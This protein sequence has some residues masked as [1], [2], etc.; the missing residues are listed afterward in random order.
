MKLFS[1]LSVRNYRLFASGQVISL[2]GTWAQR[3][4][5][6]WLV[7]ELS[8]NSGV[9]LGITTGL[10]FLPMLLF[11]LYGGVLADR[12][13]KRRL[14][15]WAQVSM[16]V[17]ALV[18]GVLDLADVVQ[19]WHVYVLAAALG[20]ATAFDSPVRQAFVTELVGPSLLANAVGL[21]S[22]AFNFARVVGPAVAGL[23]IASIGTAWVFLINAS[24][25]VAVIAGLAAIRSAEL[26]VG[27][28]AARRK[29]AVLEGLRYV[30]SQPTLVAIIVV[31]GIVGCLGFN[32]QITSALIVKN[33]FH[34][35]AE[36]Y[37]L[38][39]ATYAV[40]SLIG[41]L[42]AARRARP[43]R[44]LVFT[45][46][47]FYGVLEIVAGLM[48]TYWLF[49]AVLIPFGFFTMTFSTTCNTTM[50]LSSS[51]GMRGR[52][53]A[54][55]LLVFMGGTPIGA[56]LVGWIAE[57]AGPR[58]SLVVGGV[59][60]VAAAVIAAAYLARRE[61]LRVEP[62]LWRRRP[63]VHVRPLPTQPIDENAL[64]G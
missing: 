8:H 50:Q 24:S 14:L 23:M 63:H 9:A 15:I 54:L 45:A 27:K 57:V 33:T 35:G 1:S 40:G 32:F 34:H 58:W 31:V 18:L 20:V 64:V 22:S 53:M 62:H 55:Y 11:G 47:A 59:A 29:G 3:V 61:R 28:P 17:L 46:A 56:P 49:F 44:R 60:S 2:S 6:D 30:R 43:S 4:A 12:Y 26:Y 21:N 37:G 16:G 52:V 51:P 19:L 25:F 13:D 42:A 10:Q 5:Q 41:A 36:S 7:L 39:S 48:P 38:I